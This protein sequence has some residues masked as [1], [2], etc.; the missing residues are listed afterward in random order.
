[1]IRNHN[2]VITW[3]RGSVYTRSSLVTVIFSHTAYSRVLCTH[4]RSVNES[5][6][7]ALPYALSGWLMVFHLTFWY[8]HTFPSATHS[9][10]VAALRIRCLCICMNTW[11]SRFVNYT[12]HNGYH[13]TWPKRVINIL[14]SEIF[15]NTSAHSPSTSYAIFKLL[16]RLKS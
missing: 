16:R 5:A 6:T 2:T 9:M 10:I 14:F 8:V 7:V 1:M 13:W 11:N 4:R 3:N 15:Q 12:A